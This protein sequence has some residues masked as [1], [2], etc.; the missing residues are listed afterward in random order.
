MSDKEVIKA[1]KRCCGGSANACSLCPYR[2]GQRCKIKQLSMDVI[3]IVAQLLKENAALREE[4]KKLQ[5]ELNVS[6]WED[7]N[8]KL[9]RENE[10]LK[11]ELGKRGEHSTE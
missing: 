10:K 7:E 8:E 9:K 6:S 1:F 4:N 3:N 2:R 5:H 11:A